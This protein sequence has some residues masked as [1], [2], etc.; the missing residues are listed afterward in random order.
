M[1]NHELKITL[2]ALVTM[3]MIGVLLN[4]VGHWLS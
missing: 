1:L 4:A 3:M 2:S